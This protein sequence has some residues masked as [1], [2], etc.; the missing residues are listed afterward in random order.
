MQL[1]DTTKVADGDRNL[2]DQNI[3]LTIFRSF[4]SFSKCVIK[5][6]VIAKIECLLTPRLSVEFR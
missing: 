2:I 6:F 5:I 4:N 1:T 3:L